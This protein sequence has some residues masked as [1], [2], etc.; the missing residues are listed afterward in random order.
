MPVG[1]PSP[2]WRLT[3]SADALRYREAAMGTVSHMASQYETELE[4]RAGSSAPLF[5][6]RSASSAPLFLESSDPEKAGQDTVI[7]FD[8]DDTLLPTW[9]ITHIMMPCLPDDLVR[10]GALPA[11][12]PFYAGLERHASYVRELLSVARAVGHVAIVTLS[13]RPWVTTSAAWYLPGLDLDKLLALLDIPVY[14]SFEQ[15]SKRT[16]HRAEALANEGVNPHVICKRWAM[17]RCLKQYYAGKYAAKR[18]VIAIGDS[19]VERDAV[20]DLMWAYSAFASHFAMPSVL[21]KTVKLIDE[22][23]L[24]L[25]G[26]ELQLLAAWLRNMADH[27]DDFDFSM[28]DSKDLASGTLWCSN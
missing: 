7:I 15:V 28:D 20:K 1:E 4:K 2:L 23:P 16:L 5:L 10:G 22:P 12:S 6:E 17:H 24:D 26:E 27:E 8:W 3:R 18:N 13:S 21:C 19:H 11:E 14:Y 9:F 25:L